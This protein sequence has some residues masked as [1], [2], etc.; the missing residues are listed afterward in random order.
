MRIQNGRRGRSLHSRLLPPPSSSRLLKKTP[1]YPAKN[2]STA[3]KHLEDLRHKT[4]NSPAVCVC[5]CVR[6]RECVCVCLLRWRDERGRRRKDRKQLL[7]QFGRILGGQIAK[8][9]P[10]ADSRL[11]GVSN[12]SR[13][14][15]FLLQMIFS[16]ICAHTLTCALFYVSG[17]RSDDWTEG[18][19]KVRGLKRHHG[20]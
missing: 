11:A 4:K 9:S 20:S 10:D 19:T 13:L 16:H 18:Q 6:V 5:V 1:V 8:D 14:F 12:Q 17:G 3:L 15:L 2:Y 7:L